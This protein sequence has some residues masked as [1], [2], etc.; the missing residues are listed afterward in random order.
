MNKQSN[1][2]KSRQTRFHSRPRTQTSSPTKFLKAPKVEKEL[3]VEKE[4]IKKVI[5]MPEAND[6]YCE[7]S[8]VYTDDEIFPGKSSKSPDIDIIKSA[9]KSLIELQ[10]EVKNCMDTSKKFHQE[11]KR[12]KMSGAN[13]ESLYNTSASFQGSRDLLSSLSKSI[14]QLNQ[15]LSMNEEALTQ[16]ADE[17]NSLKSEIQTL[18]EK[19]RQQHS[20]NLENDTK[21]ISC[22][23]ACVVM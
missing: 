10:I 15:R 7:L 21:K 18:Q 16:R 14:V 5:E 22:T 8:I 12:L 3:K 23:N 17:N 20:C 19:I 6:D 11:T 1:L 2:L 9:H 13:L 4:P